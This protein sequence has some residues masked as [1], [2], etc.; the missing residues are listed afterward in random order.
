MKL[1]TFVCESNRKYGVA[2]DVSKLVSCMHASQSLDHIGSQRHS[3][4]EH[5]VELLP[6]L[7]PALPIGDIPQA[8]VIG[9]WNLY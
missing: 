6:S 3:M 9:S 4:E 2:N 5:D 7:V 1:K 8:E